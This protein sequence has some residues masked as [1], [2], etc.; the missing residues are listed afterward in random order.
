[1]AAG[2]AVY[3]SFRRPSLDLTWLPDD[4]DVIVV[5]NDDSLDRGALGFPRIRHLDSGGNVGFGAAVDLALA[6]VAT[7]RVV[8]VN[9]DTRLRR[10][11]WAALV[12]AGPD[13]VVAVPLIDSEGRPT[14]MVSPYP[15]PASLVLTAFRA[16]RWFP[17]GG[18]ARRWLAPALGQWGRAHQESLTD[19]ASATALN[20]SWPASARWASG[21][22]A[23]FDADRLRA[24]GG[25]DRRYFL[26]LEDTDLGK[27]L[28]ARFPDLHVRLA[29]CPPGIHEVGGSAPGGAAWRD[30]QR[31]YT[32]SAVTYAS[33]E[34]G[35][36]WRVAQALLGA[37]VR[38]LRRG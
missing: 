34:S 28:A 13:E 22:L 29:A 19:A 35:P 17:R 27:R 18:R 36:G 15:T 23:S 20:A 25:F 8:L 7:R 3:V 26:Y 6:E 11:H 21:A 24:V 10:E 1:M 38:W 33:A 37:R 30:A 16:G 31:H 14:A 4:A 12:D 5:H 2:T 9:P 32:E